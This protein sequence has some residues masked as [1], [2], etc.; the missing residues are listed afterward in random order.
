[1]REARLWYSYLLYKVLKKPSVSAA[2][3]EVI[4]YSD[5]VTNV[6]NVTNALRVAS[7]Q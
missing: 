4:C 6:T 2:R 7:Y 5:Q 1:M 3:D